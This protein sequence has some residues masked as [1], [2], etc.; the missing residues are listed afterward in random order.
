MLEKPELQDEKII[1]CLQ[2]EYG[3]NI[4]QVAFLP[5]GA[6]GNTA[7]YHLV[8]DD[9][10][11][12]FLKLRGGLFDEASVAVPKYLSDLGVRQIIPPLPTQTGKLW[13]SLDR[14]KV[15]L[16]PFVEGHNG[17]EVNLSDRQRVEFGTALKKFHTADIPA[18]ITNRVRREVFSPQWRETVKLFLARIE[19]EAFTDP[20][21]VEMAAFLKSKRDETFELVKRA[22]RLA[23]ALQAQTTE[24]TLCHGDIHAW[25]LLVDINGALYMVDWDTL[26]FAPKERDLM[27]VG[28]GLGGNG[29][30]LQEEE[31]LFYQGYGQTEIN[32]IAMAYYRYERI[33]EDIAVYS[34]QI[35]LTDEGGED[36][37]QGLENLKSNFLP[38]STI[39]IAFQSD[40]TL[41]KG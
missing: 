23:L 41:R 3:L 37:R 33:I 40:K 15:I 12:Y 28:G 4:I 22:E 5:L 8:A 32:P 16:Y 34:E 26:I 20:V 6:D 13:S 30:T 38:N 19:S 14:Y 39:E 18:A 1:A 31:T 11:Q 2:R 17:F 35:F 10:R 9:E 36:R 27:F 21:A 25:N 7:V 24:I 29:H